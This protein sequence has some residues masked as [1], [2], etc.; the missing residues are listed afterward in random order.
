LTFEIALF[1]KMILKTLRKRV[2][3]WLGPWLAYW[4]IKVLSRTMRFEEINPEIPRAFWEKGSHAI[5]AY[6]QGRLLMMPVEY[7][8]RK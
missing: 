3:A 5:G 4:V 1:T 6:W 2:V 7:R 8:G